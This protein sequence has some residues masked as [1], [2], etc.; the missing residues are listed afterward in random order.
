MQT[1]M[2]LSFSREH[3]NDVTH[4]P[5]VK[6]F[7]LPLCSFTYIVYFCPEERP[8]VFVRFCFYLVL[9]EH[10]VC[11]PA[12][13]FPKQVFPP[14]N[15]SPLQHNHMFQCCSSLK[16]PCEEVFFFALSLAYL[17]MHI[18]C[19][20]WTLLPW[21]VWFSCFLRCTSQALSKSHVDPSW[22]T[23]LLLSH[24]DKLFTPHHQ[25]RLLPAERHLSALFSLLSIFPSF[26]FVI[27][28]LPPHVFILMTLN[29]SHLLYRI[30]ESFCIV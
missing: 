28:S 15:I 11:L 24:T 3:F 8:C 21:L 1:K 4:S 18:H 6:F 13:S 17:T 16:D 9:K 7:V 2:L 26:L 27:A 19:A 14:L 29:A 12:L 5:S 25:R 10:W 22:F 30:L 23:L 20:L